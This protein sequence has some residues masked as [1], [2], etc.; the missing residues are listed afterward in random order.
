MR[1]KIFFFLFLIGIIFIWN[2]GSMV[3]ATG[4]KSP[5]NAVV[6]KIDNTLKEALKAQQAGDM[7]KAKELI[8]EAYFGTFEASDM[9]DAI[10]EHVSSQKALDLESR[11]GKIRQSMTSQAP[12]ASTENLIN[13][14]VTELK[15][16]IPALDQAKAVPKIKIEPSSPAPAGDK[17]A[18]PPSVPSKQNKSSFQDQVIVLKG[19]L[20]KALETYRSGDH[21]KAKNMVSEAYFEQF[22]GMEAAIAVKSGAL[23]TE[24]ESLFGKVIS[25]M[26]SD[27]SNEEV[28]KMIKSLEAKLDQAVQLLTQEKEGKTSLFF[29]S[30]IIITREGFEAILIVSAL[31]TYLVRIG[32]SDKVKF[33]YQGSIVA[34]LASF[35]IAFLF[36]T[37]FRTFT[38]SREFLEGATMILASMVLFYV[39]YWLI[40]KAQASKW[41]QFIQKKVQE[42]LSK[43][44]LMALWF[45]AFLA[46]FREGAETVLF[47]QALLSSAEMGGELNIILGFLVG[48]GLLVVLFLLFKY[49]SLKIPIK[50]FFTVTSILLYYLA[51]VFAGKGIVELQTAGVL[52]AT[53]VK[54]I[55]TISIFGIYPTLQSL[56]IQGLLLIAALFAMIYVFLQT[57]KVNTAR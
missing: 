48:C 16:T 7:E 13:E 21:K 47:Y 55:P 46:V 36:Q 40:S 43:G 35:V 4:E 1:S 23:K 9:E 20:A 12:A 31:A 33:I 56:L 37:L 34:M 11:F 8:T 26:G 39:S 14:L 30:L 32:H 50:T 18:G 19:T 44:S 25:L 5:W 42:S 51:F 27:A 54:Y 15:K 10:K 28:E 57:P 29:N 52:E 24:L 53:P 22:E 41:Q 6:A 45:T 17:P 38:S 2:N 49:G 3:Q